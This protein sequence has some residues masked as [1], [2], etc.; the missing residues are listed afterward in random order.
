MPT[1]VVV[2]A[3][4]LGAVAVA[5]LTVYIARR[6]ILDEAI[7]EVGRDDPIQL[8][9]EVRRRLGDAA[10]PH[11][12]EQILKPVLHGRPPARA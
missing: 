1:I 10:S 4:W 9:A 5:W 7:D 12:V 6:V 11:E 2:A 8:E 3:L